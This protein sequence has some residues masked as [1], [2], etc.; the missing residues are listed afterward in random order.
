MFLFKSEKLRM[1]T[2]IRNLEKPAI[3][4]PTALFM[5][6]VHGLAL[7][8]FI[9]WQYDLGGCWCGASLALGDRLP[10]HHS[11]LASTDCPQKF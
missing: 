10:G 4:W 6:A 7:L 1:T 9:P 8:A 5:V 11:R 2:T 3:D